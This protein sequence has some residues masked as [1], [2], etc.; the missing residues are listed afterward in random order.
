MHL[1]YRQLL[2]AS[3]TL[4]PG[5]STYHYLGLFYKIALF[6][7][8]FSMPQGFKSKNTARKNDVVTMVVLAAQL[9]HSFGG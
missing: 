9:C 4:L 1:Q 6:V 8:I 3:S 7:Y 2:P 5:V